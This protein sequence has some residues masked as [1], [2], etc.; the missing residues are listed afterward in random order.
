MPYNESLVNFKEFVIL[1]DLCFHVLPIGQLK[2]KD[3]N[4]KVNE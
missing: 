2:Y 3:Y 1:S 4:G